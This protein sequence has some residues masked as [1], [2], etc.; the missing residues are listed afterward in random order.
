MLHPAWRRRRRPRV[1]GA[2]QGALR[3]TIRGAT[4]D[5]ANKGI[6]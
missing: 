5:A 1:S 6:L 2:I 4:R 3:V